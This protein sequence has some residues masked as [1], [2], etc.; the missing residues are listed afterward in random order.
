MADIASTAG[1]NHRFY[2][3]KE[4]NAR[5][6][7]VLQPSPVNSAGDNVT[8]T[9]S[10][11]TTSTTTASSSQPLKFI[12]RT[13]LN[14]GTVQQLAVASSASASQPSSTVTAASATNAY[15]KAAAA[16]S[17]VPTQTTQAVPPPT[18]TPTTA[19]TTAVAAPTTQ[20]TQA[21]SGVSTTA[22]TTG[23]M[24]Q[25]SSEAVAAAK[26]ITDTLPVTKA[27]FGGY[28][29]V[30]V[31]D[32]DAAT[33]KAGT[34]YSPFKGDVSM[35]APT[36]SVFGLSQ[37]DAKPVSSQ[38]FNFA[39]A[40]NGRDVNSFALDLSG[41]GLDASSLES[42]LKSGALQISFQKWNGVGQVGPNAANLSLSG[43]SYNVAKFG[44][45]QFAGSALNA[46]THMTGDGSTINGTFGGF[47]A[48]DGLTMTISSFN[49]TINVTGAAL[50]TY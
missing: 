23:V 11:T 1:V 50:T 25:P 16:S 8:S 39:F 42:N 44:D 9:P 28:K 41:S 21:V 4:L 40:N 49:P 17:V 26:A 3:R 33:L 29:A 15:E 32:A 37:T 36:G 2:S 35:V 14:G 38:T 30:Q 22:N 10:S 24:P 31:N 18:N 47:S 19:S 6:T 46:R 12:S 20:T 43:D 5:T 34:Q 27:D 45:G 7:P 48:K 13:A